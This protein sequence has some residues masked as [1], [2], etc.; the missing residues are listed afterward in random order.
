VLSK[1]TRSLGEALEQ[2]NAIFRYMEQREAALERELTFA[3]AQLTTASTAA[4]SF[5][6]QT[7][8]LQTEVGRLSGD[9]ERFQASYVQ[10]REEREQLMQ[11]VMALEQQRLQLAARLSSIP[12]LRRAIREAVEA[13]RRAQRQARAHTL[14]ARAEAAR[15]STTEGNRGYLVRNGQPTAGRSTMWIR[16]HEPEPLLNQ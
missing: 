8:E 15:Q 2:R 12:D 1:K 14:L 4:A 11:R 13:R 3:K 6:E 7:Q 10:L 5:G 16:V 9:V